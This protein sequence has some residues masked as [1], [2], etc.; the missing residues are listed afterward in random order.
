MN[1]LSKWNNLNCKRKNIQSYLYT[2]HQYFINNNYANYMI[3][4]NDYFVI[5]IFCQQNGRKVEKSSSLF[6]II[7]DLIMKPIVTVDNF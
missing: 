5:Y 7:D 2:N 1:L 6:D 3:L 4:I